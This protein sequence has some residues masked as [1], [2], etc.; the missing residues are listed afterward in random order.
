MFSIIVLFL[1]SSVTSQSTTSSPANQTTTPP[2]PSPPKTSTNSSSSTNGTAP[3]PIT[4]SQDACTK[5]SFASC[6]SSA[7][8]AWNSVYYACVDAQTKPCAYSPQSV[9]LEARGCAYNTTASRCYVA[10]TTACGFVEFDCTRVSYCTWQNS[11]C[12]PLNNTLVPC[13]YGDSVTCSSVSGCVWSGGECTMSSSSQC[14]EIKELTACVVSSKICYVHPTLRVCFA[15]D[16]THSCLLDANACQYFSGCQYS[17]GA[18]KFFPN[19]VTTPCGFGDYA[20]CVSNTGCGWDVLRG[21]CKVSPITTIPYCNYDHFAACNAVPGCQFNTTSQ[22]CGTAADVG[23]PCNY[24]VKPWCTSIAGCSWD[25]TL[26][27][28]LVS[29]GVAGCA[30]GDKAAC[31]NAQR[32]EWIGNLCNVSDVRGPCDYSTQYRCDSTL[33][34]QY[35]N[36]GCKVVGSSTIP[37]G[38]GESLTCNSVQG[39]QWLQSKC[40]VVG[41]KSQS[42]SYA[43]VTACKSL[44]GCQWSGKRNKCVIRVLRGCDYADQAACKESNCVWQSGK[45]GAKLS[46][47]ACPYS[48]NDCTSVIGCAWNYLTGSCMIG[49]T[50]DEPCAFSD[51]GACVSLPGCGW[52]SNTSTCAKVPATSSCYYGDTIACRKTSGCD[53]IS[54][55]CQVT[56]TTTLC[57]YEDFATC[58]ETRGCSWNTTLKGCVLSASTTRACDFGTSAMCQSF[59]G[60]IWKDKSCTIA[61]TTPGVVCGYV[62]QPACNVVAGCE[63]QSSSNTCVASTN[64]PAPCMIANKEA[65]DIATA[66]QWFNETCSI[67]PVTVPCGYTD[68]RL[69]VLS[70]GCKWVN[71]KCAVQ[72]GDLPCTYPNSDMCSLIAGCTW[73]T[74]TKK[75]VMTLPSTPCG[76]ADRAAC[77]IASGCQMVNGVCQVVGTSYPCTYGDSVTCSS[78][79]GCFWNAARTKCVILRKSS[80]TG[81]CDVGDVA[82][83]NYVPGCRWNGTT[84]SFLPSRFPCFYQ[85]VKECTADNGCEWVSNISQCVLSQTSSPTLSSCGYNTAAVC[86]QNSGCVWTFRPLTQAYGCASVGSLT[87][88]GYSQEA[89]C[90]NTLGCVWNANYQ[91]CGINETAMQLCRTVDRSLCLMYSTLCSWDTKSSMCGYSPLST[92]QRLL[93]TKCTSKNCESDEWV[94]TAINTRCD[95]QVI[96]QACLRQPQCTYTNGVCRTVTEECYKYTTETSCIQSRCLWSGIACL[97]PPP[98]FL[99]YTV[100]VNK[101][102]ELI[103]SE[104]TCHHSLCSWNINPVIPR[105]V[106]FTGTFS[107]EAVQGNGCTMRTETECEMNFNCM[108]KSDSSTCALRSSRADVPAPKRLDRINCASTKE[109]T[110]CVLGE[111][112]WNEQTGTCVSNATATA[113]TDNSPYASFKESDKVWVRSQYGVNKT[114]STFSISSFKTDLYSAMAPSLPILVSSNISAVFDVIACDVNPSKVAFAIGNSLCKPGCSGTNFTLCPAGVVRCVCS[115]S[116]SILKRALLQTTTT[117]TTTQCFIYVTVNMLGID[118]FIPTTTQDIVSASTTLLKQ[119]ESYLNTTLKASYSLQG[120][121]VEV[122]TTSAI[123]Q[124]LPPTSAPKNSTDQTVNNSPTPASI[125]STPGSTFLP[126]SCRGFELDMKSSEFVCTFVYDSWTSSLQDASVDFYGRTYTGTNDYIY[127]YTYTKY[128][129]S[130]LSDNNRYFVT[131][132]SSYSSDDCNKWCNERKSCLGFDFASDSGVC[133]FTSVVSSTGNI[134]PSSSTN[135]FYLKGS[136]YR[137]VLQTANTERYLSLED[138]QTTLYKYDSITTQT[139]SDCTYACSSR[140]RPT[141]SPQSEKT[142][143]GTM[144][145]RDYVY[146]CRF[147]LLIISILLMV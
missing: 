8:C 146:I 15:Y 134:K 85:T 39:C 87:A 22:K 77:G 41:S 116:S 17:N 13:G 64:P 34:C 51:Y 72:G 123:I 130:S 139:L 25:S 109:E 5:L 7:A 99:D 118:G 136:S 124:T 91:Q 108:W 35:L 10:P 70:I 147:F 107:I 144:A 129:S 110:S 52:N 33:G 21:A 67:R 93:R 20:S 103:D 89:A 47:G 1:I 141:S 101:S 122:D 40:Q 30:Y 6:S 2:T 50:K 53:W 98:A 73:N 111:C 83:C 78:V 96:Q 113:A 90:T 100:S 76:Y 112:T 29:T 28:C 60:C 81:P 12:V 138:Q 31:L 16:R 106:K 36:G 132:V 43:D 125:W 80:S 131:R 133:T 56:T 45:C 26:G 14:V 68:F 11:A 137:P 140:F 128:T 65:C 102:C 79:A 97:Y 63:W 49:G 74:T 27:T 86:N 115:A 105:C 32:C 4:L 71:D 121:R 55:S 66:C 19:N 69:C 117:P 44:N 75:C 82:A 62:H 142:T 95:T 46:V 94:C 59:F 48:A 57:G 58:V 3:A 135:A 42:C 88:C 84:C 127:E 18:C 92:C 54:G 126:N 145:R 61:S 120:V 119:T 24:G 114:A 104:M 9:C 143:S 38:Y 23:I 37:C